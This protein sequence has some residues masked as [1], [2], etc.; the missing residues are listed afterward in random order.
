MKKC[1]I[2]LIILVAVMAFGMLMYLTTVF[3]L[4]PYRNRVISDFINP[5]SIKSKENF[6][7]EAEYLNSSADSH[8]WV[9]LVHQ[10]RCDHS[11]VK[12]LADVYASNGYHVVIPDNRAHG[13]SGG[14]YIGMGYL[15]Q[16]D[17]TLWIDY[18]IKCDANATVIIHGMSMGAS[19]AM[20]LSDNTLP[21]NVKVII[22]DSGY[23]S[24]ESYLRHKFEDRFHISS[25][26]IVWIANY[27]F[28]LFAGYYMTDASA[29]AAVA[30]AKLPILFI[31]G[32]ADKTV[33]IQHVYNLY[34]NCTSEKDLFVVP[35]AGHTEAVNIEK[36][37]YW[38]QIF[39]FI[40]KH[41]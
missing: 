8:K 28:K 4:K 11:S 25:D 16:E 14:R 26:F 2:M 39:D 24:A 9:L 13:H 19:A 35:R 27:G 17:L 30:N 18:I 34:Y 29:I 15:D 7:L 1:K 22:E 33:P 37:N 31:H 21:S 5:V 20:M 38:K 36:E 12:N 3:V 23:E 41:S 6:D 40:E 32:E 10:Y